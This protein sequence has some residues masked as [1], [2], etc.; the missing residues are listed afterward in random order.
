MWLCRE[1]R[2]IRCFHAAGFELAPS[3]F[4]T[5]ALFI[6]AIKPTGIGNESYPL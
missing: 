4:W 1:Q 3:D 5:T 6:A 2:K